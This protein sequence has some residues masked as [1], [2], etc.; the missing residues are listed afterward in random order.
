MAQEI[1]RDKPLF[2]MEPEEAQA[3]LG[4]IQEEGKTAAGE[5]GDGYSINSFLAAH[6]NFS[7]SY[8]TAR[9]TINSRVPEV[10]ASVSRSKT[11]GRNSA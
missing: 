3:A 2:E 11:G 1:D 4:I 7:E 6:T 5:I 10:S 9:E 8:I